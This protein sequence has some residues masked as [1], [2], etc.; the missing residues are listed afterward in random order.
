V[1]TRIGRTTAIKAVL[2]GDRALLAAAGLDGLLLWHSGTG[3]VRG[4][5]R[6]RTPARSRRVSVPLLAGLLVSSAGAARRPF[7]PIP[8]S[9]IGPMVE[10]RP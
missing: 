10:L 8:A 6:H 1:L 5:D 9:D 2:G 7:S 3:R 4:P